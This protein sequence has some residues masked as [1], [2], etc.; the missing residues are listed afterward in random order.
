MDVDGKVAAIHAVAGIVA[1]YISFIIYS[2]AIAA[3]GSNEVLAV[4]IALIILYIVG[5]VSERIFGKE[6]VGG[7]KGW[8][9]SGIVPYFFIWIMVWV[10]FAN[11]R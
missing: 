10:I 3:I 2:G 11:I 7:L 5:Q 6:E 4:I 1:G 9:W 8:L